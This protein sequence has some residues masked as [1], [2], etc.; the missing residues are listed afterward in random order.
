M[1]KLL[2]QGSNWHYSSDNMGSLNLLSHQARPTISFDNEEAG[3]QL[4]NLTELEALAELNPLNTFIE[5]LLC[6][7]GI[8]KGEKHTSLRLPGTQGRDMYRKSQ[9]QGRDG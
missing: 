2:G 1:W 8:Y 3:P 4:L 6:M 5:Q 9:I 7:P